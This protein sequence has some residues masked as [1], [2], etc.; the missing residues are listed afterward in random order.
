MK[1]DHMLPE[2]NRHRRRRIR[3]Q[4]DEGA[5]LILALAFMLVTGLTVLSLVTWA[6]NSLVQTHAFNQASDL[7]YATGAAVQME[8]QTLRYSYE[9]ATSSFTT[10]TPGGGSNITMNG[11]SISVYCN[12]V[13]NPDSAATRVVTFDACSS[14]ESESACVIA[15]YL[16][17]VLSF[18][19]YSENNVYGCISLSD[20]VTC[21][22]AMSI[23]GWTLIG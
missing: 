16:Q 22:T 11:V 13:E 19:D 20:Q 10:C 8:A 18:D 12:I 9:A 5:I 14:T 15:P 21:G 17:A 3:E 2:V 6:G 4:N 7:D 23:D 1:S